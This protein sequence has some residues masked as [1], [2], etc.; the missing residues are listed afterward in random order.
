MIRRF[1]LITEDFTKENGM[2]TQTLKLK[3]NAVLARWK[4]NLENLY[5]RK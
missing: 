1:E 4:E 5:A 2:L 3:R